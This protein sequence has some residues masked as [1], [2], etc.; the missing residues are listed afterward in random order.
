MPATLKRT[1]QP[2]YDRVLVRRAEREEDK[3]SAGGI[4]IPEMARERPVEG[5][6]ISVGEG[7][8]D[9]TAAGRAQVPMSVKV[10]DTVLF[11]R[12]S[13]TEVKLSDD[14]EFLILREEEILGILR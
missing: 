1:L 2:L 6:V 7:R 13:G 12:Y 3:V 10:G 11:G 9:L 8:L 4:H 14:G 5:E